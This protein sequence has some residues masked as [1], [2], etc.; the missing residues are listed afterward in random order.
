MDKVDNLKDISIIYD[1]IYKYYLPLKDRIVF[2]I[3]L[4]LLKIPFIK[5]GIYYAYKVLS[6]KDK[7]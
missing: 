4:F 5:E 2:K 3:T 7:N 1:N 6:R